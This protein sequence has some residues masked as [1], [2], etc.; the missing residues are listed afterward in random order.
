M[1]ILVLTKRQYMGKDLIDD[2]FGRF[3]ELPLELASLGH[4]VHGLSLSYRRRAEICTTDSTATGE[5][6]VHWH[7]INLMRNCLPG[8]RKYFV[9]ARRLIDDIQPDL[10][11]AGSDAYHAIFGHRLV[12]NS[13]IKLVIDLY[14]NFESYPATKIPGTLPL[15]KRAVR[16][17]DGIT[18]VSELL[19]HYVRDRYERCKP[20]FVLENAIRSDLFHPMDRKACRKLL[21]L[22]ERAKIIGTAGALNK[23]RGIRTLYRGF[24][25][26]AAADK[27]LHLAVAGPRHPFSALPHERYIHDLGVLPFEQVPVF[28][29]SL[30]VAIVCNRPTAFGRY[31]F[32][33][34][35]REIMACGIPLVAADVGALKEM[36]QDR[37][38]RLFAADDPSSLARALNMQLERPSFID[39]A[40]P[41]WTDMAGRLD[42]FLREVAATRTSAR[43]QRSET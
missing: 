19:A 35:A 39:E 4:Q 2:R 20:A 37:P 40:V 43:A 17:A 26:L 22:P 16:E 14:D 42:K 36:L 15:F 33:Q 41:S 29:N 27:D 3:R 9:L 7:S 31:N 23:N 30:D 32:P 18:C 34:K 11:W 1:K 13:N 6:Q 5:A 12:A 8:F 24:Q 38:E 21:G 25:L 28:L 10:I